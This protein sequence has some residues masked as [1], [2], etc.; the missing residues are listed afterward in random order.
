MAPMSGEATGPASIEA[1][2]GLS[3]NI[4][5]EAQ[6]VSLRMPRS[7]YIRVLTTGFRIGF[8]L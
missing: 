3:P 5:D 8:S 6:A 2:P 1:S 7:G 4:G